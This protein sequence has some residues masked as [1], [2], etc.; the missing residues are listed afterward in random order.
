MQGDLK[1]CISRKIFYDFA[2]IIVGRSH[3]LWAFISQKQATLRACVKADVA[4]ITDSDKRAA[5]RA[6]GMMAPT[7]ALVAVSIPTASLLTA[8]VAV[9][10]LFAVLGLLT[11]RARAVGTGNV[12]FLLSLGLHLVVLTTAATGGTPEDQ[13]ALDNVV[14]ICHRAV[15]INGG[16][17][18]RR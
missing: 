18:E 1:P 12:F 16:T 11:C 15:R 2:G 9:G 14:Y 3:T 5:A 17:G 7:A 6:T 13:S 10:P 8:L 4:G